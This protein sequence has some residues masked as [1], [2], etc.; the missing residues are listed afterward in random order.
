MNDVLFQPC[1]NSPYYCF[2]VPAGNYAEIDAL[3]LP[4]GWCVVFDIKKERCP[5]DEA[6]FF[7]VLCP[8]GTRATASV[9]DPVYLKPG[10]YQATM[11]DENF[12]PVTPT[13]S[14][15]MICKTVIC[16]IPAGVK[17]A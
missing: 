6:D 4:Q 10:R 5:C 2:D 13:P 8:D 12:E 7:P 3:D 17:E 11:V 14:D 9:A 1:P 15:S 16:G